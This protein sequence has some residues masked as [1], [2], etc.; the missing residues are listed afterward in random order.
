[1]SELKATDMSDPAVYGRLTTDQALCKMFADE[2]CKLDRDTTEKAFQAIAHEKNAVEI[3]RAIGKELDPKSYSVML[4]NIASVWVRCN[5][6]DGM[7]LTLSDV[8]EG[9]VQV[10]VAGNTSP[11]IVTEGSTPP[12]YYLYPLLVEYLQQRNKLKEARD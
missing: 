1:M 12:L 3:F 4:N 2:L 9:T 10:R 5:S 11:S 7:H 6:V 8:K